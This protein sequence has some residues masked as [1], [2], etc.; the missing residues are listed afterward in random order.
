MMNRAP[1]GVVRLKPKTGE[2][3]MELEKNISELMKRQVE[4]QELS[5][6][7]EKIRVCINPDSYIGK[8]ILYQTALLHEILAEL[9]RDKGSR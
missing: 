1:K 6:K 8:E 3:M 9:R 5:K 2:E 7:K 4:E